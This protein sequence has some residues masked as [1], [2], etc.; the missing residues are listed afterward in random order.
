MHHAH[1]MMCAELP[2]CVPGTLVPPSDPVRGDEHGT[3][4]GTRGSTP[5]PLEDAVHGVNE[6]LLN[7][8]AR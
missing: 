2:L 3:G 8:G 7:P 4:D 6:L 1:R 5:K